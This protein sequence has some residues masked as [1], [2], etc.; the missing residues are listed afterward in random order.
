[1]S[2]TIAHILCAGLI[3]WAGQ[4]FLPEELRPAARRVL[5]EVQTALE[6]ARLLSEVRI[7]LRV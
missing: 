4:R 6:P 7:L 5:W 1:M 2:R 3:L